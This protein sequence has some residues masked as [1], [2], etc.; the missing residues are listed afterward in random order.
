MPFVKLVRRMTYVTTDSQTSSCSCAESRAVASAQSSPSSG[1]STTT[2][3]IP[4]VFE[5]L[6][7]KQLASSLPQNSNAQ[8]VQ[9][10]PIQNDGTHV[11]NGQNTHVPGHKPASTSESNTVYS[12]LN[13]VTAN[14]N[15][16][17]LPKSIFPLFGTNGGP[18]NRSEG[19][20]DSETTASDISTDPTG[21][22]PSNDGEIAGNQWSTQPTS[23]AD[24]SQTL[25]GNS[26]FGTPSLATESQGLSAVT[27]SQAASEQISI[28]GINSVTSG[29]IATELAAESGLRMFPTVG[30]EDGSLTTASAASGGATLDVS[31]FESV[32]LRV[33]SQDLP[34]PVQ[35]SLRTLN[36]TNPSNVSVLPA[37]GFVAGDTSITAPSICDE[38]A[39]AIER[40]L[41]NSI[42]EGPT[43]IQ[44][45][46][47]RPDLGRIKLNLSLS[48]GAISIRIITEN[49]SSQQIVSS[50]L[51]N[52][53]QSLAN[54]GILCNQCQIAC[55]RPSLESGPR[56]EAYSSTKSNIR[57]SRNQPTSPS[58]NR[59]TSVLNFVA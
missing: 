38:L 15:S 51:T 13:P 44:I 55:E 2:A 10:N 5:L 30:S 19:Q 14:L 50:Q 40:Q 37:Q 21:V 46:L 34:V 25:S 32:A 49:Q 20:T 42:E 6:F 45:Q 24:F 4:S 26:I 8:S 27:S 54:S 11:T 56:S 53:Q 31:Q 1:H 52:L 16:A 9:G 18:E 47:D 41:K 57:W 22:F 33:H 7:S 35:K 12:L 58:S 23:G 3:G 48:N 39:T 36:D 17:P 59:S 43:T 29:Q 28:G